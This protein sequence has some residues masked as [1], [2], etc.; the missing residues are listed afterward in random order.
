MNK[1]NY[2]NK[3]FHSELQGPSDLSLKGNVEYD[4]VAKWFSRLT[5]DDKCRFLG[6]ADKHEAWKDL[7]EW[8]PLGGLDWK[9]DE[10]MLSN[11]IDNMFKQATP[12]AVIEKYVEWKIAFPE[13]KEQLLA[14]SPNDPGARMLED[15]Y[16]Y[17]LLWDGI[18]PRTPGKIQNEIDAAAEEADEIIIVTPTSESLSRQIT[19]LILKDKLHDGDK[20]FI[21][22]ERINELKTMEISSV[23]KEPNVEYDLKYADCSLS[24]FLHD[25]GTIKSCVEHYGEDLLGNH[26]D[27]AVYH[28]AKSGMLLSAEKGNAVQ[29]PVHAIKELQKMVQE[30]IGK[31]NVLEIAGL[32]DLVAKLNEP[33]SYFRH[34]MSNGDHVIGVSTRFSIDDRM[35][36]FKELQDTIERN[37]EKARSEFFEY[38]GRGFKANNNLLDRLM[39]RTFTPTYPLPP[40][41]DLKIEGR[42]YKQGAVSLDEIET[43]KIP[44]DFYN[45]F[46]DRCLQPDGPDIDVN[47][48][49]KMPI[50]SDAQVFDK[51]QE[52]EKHRSDLRAKAE[53]KFQKML[54]KAFCNKETE[55]KSIGR[56]RVK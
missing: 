4:D 23:R 52:T 12:E 20:I 2:N 33:L 5:L 53:N 43:G 17:N 42:Q 6:F 49:P 55:S 22:D 51:K 56:V 27:G 41:D 9:L 38:A 34:E 10:G 32:R 35:G 24:V 50:M 18:N 26:V 13:R 3:P 11:G 40:M 37:Y 29:S 39:R 46:L 7:M 36:A 28:F 48:M 54:D 44:L 16:E 19:D 30:N 14:L 1:E 8:H 45:R 15:M 47:A 21:R 25:N 31:M